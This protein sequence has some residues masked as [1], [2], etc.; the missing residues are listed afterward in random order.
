MKK[1]FACLLC[2]G[3]L[4]GCSQTTAKEGDLV[5]I[6]FVGKMDGEAFDGGSASGQIVELGAGQY[7]PGFEDGIIGMKR[8]ETKEINVTFPDYYYEELA[9]KDAVFE[10]TVQNIYREVK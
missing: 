2:L 8:G 6:D 7:I 9:G 5:K 3:I 4:C 10:I 1:V